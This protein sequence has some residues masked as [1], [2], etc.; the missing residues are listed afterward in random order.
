MRHLDRR[1]HTRH[2]AHG[3]H[4]GLVLELVR[5]LAGIGQVG[6]AAA[7]EA[8][9]RHHRVQRVLGLRGQGI[10]TDGTARAALRIERVAHGRRQDDAA[11]RVGQAFRRAVAHRS[12]QRMRGAEVDA[13]RDAALVGVGRLPGFGDL[14][15][16]HGV[17]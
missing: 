7:H 13:H 11:L 14:Q 12:D 2:S 8:L 1:L 4:A 17:W 5:Q 3:H 9:D 6:Q 10:E 15:Q 16:G